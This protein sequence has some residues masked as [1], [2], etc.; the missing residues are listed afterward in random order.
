MELQNLKISE[1]NFVRAGSDYLGF[2]WS[3]HIAGADLKK[4]TWYNMERPDGTT[5]KAV[6]V[7]RQRMDGQMTWMIVDEDGAFKYGY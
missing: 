6:A 3:A 7:K 5:F 2:A 4:G 1:L